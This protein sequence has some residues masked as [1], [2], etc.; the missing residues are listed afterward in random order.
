VEALTSTLPRTMAEDRL[1]ALVHELS[2]DVPDGQPPQQSAEYLA[3]FIGVLGGLPDEQ[4]AVTSCI[5]AGRPGAGVPDP[6]AVPKAGDEPDLYELD[7]HDLVPIKTAIVEDLLTRL[8]TPIDPFRGLVDQ[9]RVRLGVGLLHASAYVRT[10]NKQ[11]HEDGGQFR[12]P[13]RQQ[14]P[15][16]AGSRLGKGSG[17][18][19]NDGPQ[20][21]RGR[22][23]FR[24]RARGTA[25]PFQDAE[26]LSCLR[27]V[28]KHR[29]CRL[30]PVAVLLCPGL[31]DL[32]G[33]CRVTRHVPLYKTCAAQLTASDVIVAIS[34]GRDPCPIRSVSFCFLMAQKFRQQNLEIQCL[35]RIRKSRFTRQRSGCHLG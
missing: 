21:G 18:T 6:P 22:R 11:G 32:Q 17:Q 9:L 26:E 31:S 14:D 24:H 25:R 29:P 10:E 3:W 30:I 34:W 4:K 33:M 20:W 7:T 35:A 15:G 13:D 16:V 5:E 23:T 2:R 8:D 28:R 19:Y 1:V 27:Q 12:Q